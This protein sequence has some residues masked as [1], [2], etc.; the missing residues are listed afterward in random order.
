MFRYHDEVGGKGKTENLNKSKELLEA[1]PKKIKEIKF[2]E[3]GIGSAMTPASCDLCLISSFESWDD[4]N[5]YREHSEH[6]KVVE[7]IN[8]VQSKV[9]SSDYEY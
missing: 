5:I 7:F 6:K 2:Y 4:L 1:L 8:S 9:F 3:V